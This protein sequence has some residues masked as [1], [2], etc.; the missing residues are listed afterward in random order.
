MTDLQ[1]KKPSEPVMGRADVLF[2]FLQLIGKDRPNDVDVYLKQL[3]I[4]DENRPIVDQLVDAIIAGDQELY[5]KY[6]QARREVGSRN[7]YGS[8]EDQAEQHTYEWALGF[9]LS[10]WIAFETAIRSMAER[11]LDNYKAPL[12]QLLYK[13]E[14]FSGK[15]MQVVDYIR[16]LRNDLVHG[17]RVPD[18]QYI[19]EAGK[20]LDELLAKLRDRL[21]EDSREMIESILQTTV[22]P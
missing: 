19:L 10:K 6:E 4:R 3:N 15:D 11:V 9:F 1:S 14:L 21:P 20:L 17:F 5:E 18:D 22:Q 12:P 7:P 16:R 13:L 8:T 2:R